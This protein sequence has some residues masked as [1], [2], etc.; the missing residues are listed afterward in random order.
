MTKA[1]KE[2]G[3]TQRFVFAGGSSGDGFNVR[4]EFRR[5]LSPGEIDNPFRGDEQ[6]PGGPVGFGH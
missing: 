6:L 4:F 3:Q 1:L 2:L 5:E